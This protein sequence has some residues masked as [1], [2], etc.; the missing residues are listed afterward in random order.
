M[1]QVQC[2]PKIPFVPSYEVANVG[3]ALGTG[4]TG[5]KPGQ[6]AA[7][8]TVAAAGLHSQGRLACR[9]RSNYRETG[10][11]RCRS[12]QAAHGTTSH[13]AKAATATACTLG[14]V[15]DTAEAT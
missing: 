10:V 6:R 7:A 5:Y 8:L 13:M 3:D 12:A 15:G 1:L 2:A 9:A 14:G 11:K 4:G